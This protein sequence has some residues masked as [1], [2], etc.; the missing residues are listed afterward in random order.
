MNLPQI[1]ALLA[2]APQPQPGTEPNPTGQLIQMLGTFAIMGFL[3]YFVLIRPQRMQ[4]KRQQELLKTLK[5][6]DRVETSSG[7]VGTIVTVKDK[8]VSLRS[9]DTKIEILKASVVR[10]DRDEVEKTA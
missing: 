5:S 1:N 4:A 3:F 7:I 2:F 10:I 6:G 8:T 9:S